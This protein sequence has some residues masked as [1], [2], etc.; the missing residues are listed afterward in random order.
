MLI[1]IFYDCGEPVSIDDIRSFQ[2]LHKVILPE[3]YV[4][5]L[6]KINGGVPVPSLFSIPGIDQESKNDPYDDFDP[7]TGR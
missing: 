1:L 3:D 5:F 2:E 4:E 6:C 7:G